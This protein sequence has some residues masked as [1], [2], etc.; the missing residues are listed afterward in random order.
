MRAMISGPVFGVGAQA[1]RILRLLPE[2]FGTA[3]A[4]ARYRQEIDTLPTWLAF[5][6][7]RVIGFLSLKRHTPVAGEIYVL[8]ILADYH[9]Q[10]IGRQLLEQAEG[11]LRGENI[12]LLQVKT[13]GPSHPSEPYRRTRA[14]YT[15]MDFQPLEELPDLWGRIIPA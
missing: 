3:S 7:G 10:G 2:W 5:D 13:L 8:G 6:E 11:F 15:A 14:F 12:R 1:E 9:R 4:I